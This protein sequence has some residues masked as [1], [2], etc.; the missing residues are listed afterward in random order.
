[1]THDQVFL[2]NKD[3][4]PDK[5]LNL[6]KVEEISSEKIKELVIEIADQLEEY[7]NKVISKQKQMAEQRAQFEKSRKDTKEVQFTEGDWVLAS[8]VRKKQNKL[9]SLWQGPFQVVKILGPKA[10]QIYNPLKGKA[11]DVHVRR[12]KFYE[13]GLLLKEE[14]IRD[15]VKR[16]LELFTVDQILDIKEIEG[17]EKCLVRWKNIHEESWLP[18]EEVADIARGKLK[19]YLQRHGA[20]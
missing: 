3:L 14:E 6:D 4:G 12:L 16:Q 20:M 1:M 5:F 8:Q 18:V 13:H 2:G 7:A 19:H 10:Y 15:H 17:Q 11:I 9:F